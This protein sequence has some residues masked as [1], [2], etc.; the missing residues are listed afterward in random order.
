[1]RLYGQ[2]TQQAA[3]ATGANTHEVN[4]HKCTVTVEVTL[5]FDL[6]INFHGLIPHY[7]KPDEQEILRKPSYTSSA[8]PRY[9]RRPCL[10]HRV[11]P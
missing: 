9:G 3:L 2:D 1:M 7:L 6:F 5:A 4:H 10:S 11:P 8:F